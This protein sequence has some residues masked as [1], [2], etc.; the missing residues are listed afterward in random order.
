V[1]ELGGLVE[2]AGHASHTA[3]NLADCHLT[4]LGV[5]VLLLEVVENLLLLVDGVLNL[6]FKGC[7]EISLSVLN[8]NIVFNKP[9]FHFLAG[10]SMSIFVSLSLR[11]C[12]EVPSNSKLKVEESPEDPKI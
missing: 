2:E 9:F 11:I 3:D 8:D 12:L 10:Q 6:L 7:R 1:V 5:A 4:E